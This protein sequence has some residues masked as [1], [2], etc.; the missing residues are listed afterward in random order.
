MYAAR[1]NGN[2]ARLEPFW[3]HAARDALTPEVI[4]VGLGDL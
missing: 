2:G 4:H 1:R 3:D